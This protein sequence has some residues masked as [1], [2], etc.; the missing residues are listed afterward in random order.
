[1]E[2]KTKKKKMFSAKRHK[3]M[4]KTLLTTIKS[5]IKCANYYNQLKM[6]RDELKPNPKIEKSLYRQSG[7]TFLSFDC[8]GLDCKTFYCRNSFRIVVS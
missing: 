1:M 6:A 2:T 7:N 5:E 4:F 8:R 3:L